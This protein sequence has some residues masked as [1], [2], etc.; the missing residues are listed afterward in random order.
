MA[1]LRFFANDADDDP[2]P[3]RSRSASL[4]GE[5]SPRDPLFTGGM[6][7][8]TLDLNASI[9]TLV[10]LFFGIF[11]CKNLAQESFVFSQYISYPPENYSTS[12]KL[13]PWEMI[14]FLSK[15]MAFLRTMSLCELLGAK[16]ESESKSIRSLAAT[17]KWWWFLRGPWWWITTVTTWKKALRAL[18]RKKQTGL[19]FG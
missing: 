10:A 7:R 2:N 14:H 16:N 5:A 8:F 1:S 18:R 11:C 3:S 12:W 6:C 4:N 19:F 13:M 15:M 9:V 17:P